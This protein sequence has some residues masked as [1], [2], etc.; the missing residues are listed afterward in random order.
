MEMAR[1]SRLKMLN[2]VGE[3]RTLE[4]GRK[5]YRL[6]NGPWAE[7]S[8]NGHNQRENPLELPIH[9]ISGSPGDNG[10][11]RMAIPTSVDV[12]VASD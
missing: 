2:I 1:L 10:R 12:Y 7:A 4:D 8:N 9:Q 3:Q 11:E 6:N 5:Q